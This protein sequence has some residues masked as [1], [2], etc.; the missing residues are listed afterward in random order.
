MVTGASTADVAL[1]LIDARNGVLEQSR[2]HAFLATLLGIPHLVRVHQQDGPRRL[3]AR[4]ASTRSARSSARFAMKLEVADLTFIPMSALTGD[5]VVSRSE[6]MPWYDGPSL[7]RHLEELHIASDRNLIDAR[8]PVQYVIRP[9]A[10][11]LPRLPRLCG[12]HR[13]RHVQARRRGHGAAVGLLHHGD[14]GL[15]AR[16]VSRPRRPS[17]A[18]AV[19]VELADDIDIARGDMI[20]RPH[21][22]PNVGQ[23]IDAMVCWLTAESDAPAGRDLHDPAHHPLDPRVDQASSS[24]AS[25]STRCTAT[26]QAADPRA[27]RDRPRSGCA[28]RS[29]CCSTRT[30]ATATPAASSSSTRRRN[31]TV[32]AG[33]ITGRDAVRVR[34]SSGTAARSPASSAPSDGRDASGSP[35]CP[36]RASRRSPS[37]SSAAWS[38]PAGRPTCSTA[39]T[40]GTA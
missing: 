28:P 29:R 32:A 3:L 9:A 21:N 13:R 33:M 6:A 30:A 40:C 8:L 7:L 35:G 12:H 37:R 26:S 5:N 14:G 22:R 1:I 31:N 36:A 38:P 18:Q 4:S 16:A 19:T 24:T 15:G 34:T 17:P 25:T 39:T 11:R 27:Q 23:D 10:G 20:C 2:R